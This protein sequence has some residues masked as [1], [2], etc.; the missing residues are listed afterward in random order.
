MADFLK[1]YGEFRTYSGAVLALCIGVS[2][3]ASGGYSLKHPSTI[4]SKTQGTISEVKCND[5]NCD[6]KVTYTIDSKNYDGHLTFNAP[7]NN[8]DKRDIWYDPKNYGAIAAGGPAPKAVD[9]GLIVGGFLV[10]I[11]GM[12]FAFWFSSLSNSGKSFVG[13]AEAASNAFSFFKRN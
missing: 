12:L 5:K 11:C 3:C 10:A 4:T 2:M 9:I 1:T 7:L 8:G 6:S 13:G